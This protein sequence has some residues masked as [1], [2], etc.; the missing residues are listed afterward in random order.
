MWEALRD[1]TQSPR[2]EVLHNID[3]IYGNAALTVGEWKVLKGTNYN[4]DWDGWYGPSGDRNFN[5]Y[6]VTRLIGSPAAVAI[7]QLGRMPDLE[8]IQ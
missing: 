4:G 8:K 5:T 1:G 6:N 3:D 2:T 7:S